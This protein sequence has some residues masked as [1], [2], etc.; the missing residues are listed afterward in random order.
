MLSNLKELYN[1]YTALLR[2]FV[3]G[4]LPETA[5]GADPDGLSALARINSTEGI[6]SYVLMKEPNLAAAERRQYL[7]KQCLGEI[8]FYS[9]RAE[10]MKLL[11]DALSREGIDHLLFKGFVLRDYYPVPELRTFGDIDLLIRPSDREACHKLMCR[12]GYEVKCDFEPVYSYLKGTEYYE[13][14]TDVM[15]VDVSD[16]ADYRGY[17]G[18]VWD[19]AVPSS[20]ICNEHVFEL[21]ADFHFIYLLTHIAKHIS[22]SGAGIRMYLDLAFFLKHFDGKLDTDYIAAELERLSLSDFA[23]TVL[24]AVE[25]WFG[26]K[27]PLP[28]KETSAEL[29]EDFL[30]FTMEGGVYGKVGRDKNAVF[31]KQQNRNSEEISKWKT[32]VF[33]VFPPVSSLENRYTYLKKH[34]WLLPVAWVHRIAGNPSSWKR[35]AGHAKGI[36]NADE[37]EARRLKRIYKELGL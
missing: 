14:H 17:F 6:L 10:Q 12:L 32:L 26:V 18:S 33:H 15:E 16:K 8:S 24:S 20:S 25:K 23:R 3:H 21:E 31:L 4:E 1:E 7:R 19:H 11:S 35:Y 37:E 29:M 30:C 36:V 13:I 34:R 22:S 28:S 5:F 9:R 27:S 2:A